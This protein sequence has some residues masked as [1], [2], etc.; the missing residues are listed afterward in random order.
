[1]YKLL[2]FSRYLVTVAIINL[3]FDRRK[4]VNWRLFEAWSLFKHIRL[5]KNQ[6]V[7]VKH[8]I[9]KIRDAVLIIPVA[10]MK[11]NF[12]I[13]AQSSTVIVLKIYQRNFSLYLL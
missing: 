13:I 2:N 10:S 8:G 6:F 4:D 12:T 1:M 9:T 11:G 5:K 7:L 3:N